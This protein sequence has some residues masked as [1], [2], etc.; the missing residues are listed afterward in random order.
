MNFN[1]WFGPAVERRQFYEHSTSQAYLAG[2]AV[3]VLLDGGLQMSSNPIISTLNELIETSR[4]GEKGFTLAAKDTQEPE[5]TALFAEGAESCRRAIAELQG[6][7]RA[8]GGDPEE[9]GSI[10]G[11]VHRGWVSVKTATTS[12]DEKAILEEC[13]R[14]E[15]YAKAR[16]AEAWELELPEPV[17]E[18]VRRQYQGVVFNHDRVRDL[19]NRY[20]A[21]P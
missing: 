4:D 14:G 8:L 7:V 21:H 6:Q 19:R 15:D 10:K 5:L 12:R 11:A 13:E 16:Y 18:L 20:S 17:R 2:L 3:S 9:S 1:R